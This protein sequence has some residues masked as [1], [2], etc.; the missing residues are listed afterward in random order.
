MVFST[1][2]LAAMRETAAIALPETVTLKRPT[3]TVDAAGGIVET[4]NTVTTTAGRVAREQPREVT[5]A[6]KTTILAEWI[7]TLPYGT[8]VGAGDVLEV[9]GQTL[10]VVGRFTGSWRTCER[11]LCVA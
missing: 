11:V 6:N 9:N 4:L 10:H 5:Q 1:L 2:E 3:R 8:D 7:V